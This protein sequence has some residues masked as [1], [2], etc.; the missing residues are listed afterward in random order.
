MVSSLVNPF[1]DS[2]PAGPVDSTPGETV[3]LQLVASAAP[4]ETI[5]SLGVLNVSGMQLVLPTAEASAIS[6]DAVLTSA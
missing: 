1:A 4:C 5:W 3:T 2:T 6:P